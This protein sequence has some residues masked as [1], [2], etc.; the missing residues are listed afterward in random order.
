MSDWNTA[1]VE[2]FRANGGKV[3]AF[4]DVPLIILHTVG[5]KSGDIREI[6]LVA[7]EHDGRFVVFA[8]AAGS[9]KHP[10]WYHNIKAN[11][12]FA[13][14]TGDETFRVRAGELGEPERSELYELQA[15]QMASFSEY[16][17]KAAPRVIPGFALERI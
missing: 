14:E 15:K 10:D 7:L 8:S 17:A 1:V 12:E 6:P 2:E 4:G 13:A 5:A 11:P 3:D 9:P 16:V